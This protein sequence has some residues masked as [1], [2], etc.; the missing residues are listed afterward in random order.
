M[1][2]II[3]QSFK[4]LPTYSP[5]ISKVKQAQSL[6]TLLIVINHAHALIAYVLLGKLAT[7]LGKCLCR[8][9][10]DTHRYVRPQLYLMRNASHHLNQVKMSVIPMQVAKTFIYT[11]VLYMMNGFP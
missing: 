1:D 7:H 5:Y 9:N 6:A 4:S 10:A 3:I 8:S 2:A 11:I